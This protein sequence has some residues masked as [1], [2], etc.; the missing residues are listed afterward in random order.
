MKKW[1]GKVIAVGLACTVLL[2]GCGQSS[3]SE[4]GGSEGDGIK[5][6]VLFSDSGV[7]AMGEKGLKNATLMAI[8]E[9][10][11]DGGVKGQQLIPVYEDYASD[12]SM[13]ATKAKKLLLQ[14]N[15]TAI[16]GGYTSASRQAMLPIIEQNDGVLVYPMS[17]EG[18]EYSKNIMYVGPVPNQGL[19]Q[20][21]PWLTENKGKKF[22]LIGSDYVFPVQVNKQ[23]KELLKLNGGEV[24][25][26]DYVPM[27]Q[28]EFASIVN[29]IKEAQPDVIFSV[30]VAESAA[31]FYKQ[32]DNYGLSPDTMPIASVVTNE[33]DLSAMGGEVGE[34]HISALP[35]FQTVDTPEN[36]E[37]VTNYHAKYGEGPIDTLMQSAYY[38]TYLLADALEKA[39][40][41]NDAGQLIG[42]FAG[43]EIM[44]P[45]GE[46][47]V[48]PENNHVKL[49]FRIGVAN[50]DAQFDII[51]ESEAPAPEPWSKLLFPDHEEPWKK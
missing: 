14:D 24:V 42:A 49:N 4:S 27:G 16:V 3:G 7:T 25:G 41:I 19:E 47:T 26:E 10:N 8:E 6:G 21:I 32:Y 38:S 12:P 33:T 35:Y 23:V 48:D 29:K 39:E 15:V 20:F 17:Y 22:F 45:E 2:A 43:L 11:A 28:S 9:I 1:L 40:D 46:V 36:K 30:L 18:E 50:K 44:A 13:A 5:I 34:G 37:F 51:E 31:A